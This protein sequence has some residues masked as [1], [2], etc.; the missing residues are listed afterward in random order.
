[1]PYVDSGLGP[2]IRSYRFE[3]WLFRGYGLWVVLKN[4][5]W[6]FGSWF[7]LGYGLLVPGYGPCLVPD[8]G[9]SKNAGRWQAASAP[10]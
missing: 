2:D 7:P 4:T 5:E 10:H 8:Y 3:L 1:M 9:R 6:G